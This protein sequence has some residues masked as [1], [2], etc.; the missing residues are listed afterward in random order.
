MT[1]DHAPVPLPRGDVRVGVDV[2]DVERFRRSLERTASFRKRVFTEDERAYCETRGDAV[3]S[4]AARFAAKEAVRKAL[5]RAVRWLDVEVRRT[6]TGEPTLALAPACTS[7]DGE[8]V[9]GG[10]V[11]LSHDGGV[12]VAVVVLTLVPG[13]P[14]DESG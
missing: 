8:T 3:A 2:V 14:L 10:S 12:A 4:Y 7:S 1:D 11:S 6:S 5:G 9:L 13:A